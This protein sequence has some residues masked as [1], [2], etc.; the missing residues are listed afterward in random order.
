M[1]DASHKSDCFMTLSCDDCDHPKYSPIIHTVV[2]EVT[3][4][5]HVCMMHGSEESPASTGTMDRKCSKTTTLD[6]QLRED[7]GLLQ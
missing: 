6:F 2:P 7:G 5:Q 4:S 3:C 1:S